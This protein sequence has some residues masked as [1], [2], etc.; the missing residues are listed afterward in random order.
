MVRNIHSFTQLDIPIWQKAACMTYIVGDVL[1]KK[2]LTVRWEKALKK[3][4]Q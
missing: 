1:I 3:L 2:S 4:A